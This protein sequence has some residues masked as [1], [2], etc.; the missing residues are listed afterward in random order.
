MPQFS[1]CYSAAHVILSSFEVQ[2]QLLLQ[3]LITLLSCWYQLHREIFKECTTSWACDSGRES[4]TQSLLLMIYGKCT[5]LHFT[6]LH[7][8]SLHFSLFHFTLSHALIT[9]FLLSQMGISP[10][11]WS[12]IWYLCCQLQRAWVSAGVQASSRSVILCVLGLGENR[13]E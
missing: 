3:I 11:A 7:F 2:L 4:P 8:T 13:I 9:F 10:A 12:A 6:S 5:S 1:Y